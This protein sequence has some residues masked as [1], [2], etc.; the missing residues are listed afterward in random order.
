MERPPFPRVLDATILSAFAAC[1]RKA[2]LE[3]ILHWKPRGQSVHLHAGASFAAGLEAARLSFFRDGEDQD[4]AIGRGVAALLAAYG[5]FECPEDSAKSATRMAGALE[6]YLSVAWPLTSDAAKPA[7]LPSGKLG[8]EFSFVTPLPINNPETGEPLLYSGRSDMFV[9][10]A[11]GLWI[12]DDKTT[13]QLGA[14]WGKQWDLRR[15]FTGY[16]WGAREAGFTVQGVLVRGVSILKTKYDHAQSLTYRAPWQVDLWLRQTL[17]DIQRMIQ[18]WEAGEWDWDLNES[19]NAYGGCP[20]RGNVCISED[21]AS[22]LE[23][24]FERREWDPILR[25][26]RK[27]GEAQQ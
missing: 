3:Y 21:P 25:K 5:D 17:R 26:E 16:V 6:Y 12:E 4:T 24:Y 19:C 23:M 14:S 11:G 1:P 15:Q 18:C 7:T 9:N 27:L 13:S 10:Y 22:W 8:V 2:M 20:F